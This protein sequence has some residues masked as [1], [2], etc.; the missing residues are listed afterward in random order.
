MAGAVVVACGY[1]LTAVLMSSVWHLVLASS[2]IG[3]GIGLAYGAMPALIMDAVPASETG[4]ANSLNTLMRSIG[5]SVSSAVAGVVLAQMTVSLG[6]EPVPSQ[7][8]FRLVLG[9]AAGAAVV[10]LVIALFLP[11]RRASVLG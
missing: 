5:T 9:V 4:S 3:A 2:V 7:E 8:G 6:G 10:A 1:G 11:K